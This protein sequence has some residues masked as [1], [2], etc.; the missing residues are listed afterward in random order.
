MA[1]RGTLFLDEIG[2]MPLTL[3]A[4]ILRALEEKR[5]ERVGGTASVQ[6]D[7]R[8]VA[9]TNRGLRAAIAARR[10]R[11]DLYFRLS[12]FP[13]TVPPLRDRPGDIILLARFFV[14]RFCR[15]MKKRPLALSP[16]AVEQLQ[17]YR[18]PGNVRELQNCIE[19]AVILAEAEAIQPRHLN[20]S[21]DAPHPGVPVSPWAHVDLS[22]SLAE[23]TRRVVFDVERVKLEEAL[24]EADNNKA[25]AADLSAD[26]LQDVRG[27]AARASPRRRAVARSPRR[28]PT[29]K[30]RRGYGCSPIVSAACVSSP[31]VTSVAVVVLPSPAGRTKWSRPPTT[32]LSRLA[33]STTVAAERSAIAGNGPIFAMSAPQRVAVGCGQ[34]A[35]CHTKLGGREHAV[36]D[37]LAVPE[38]LVLRDRFEGVADRMAEV[39]CAPR[40]G[41]AFVCLHDRAP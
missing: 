14:E 38:A 11:E 34:C 7:V 26:H 20:L 37:G 40:A 1:H 2:E 29:R 24:K 31:A 13:I 22:G 8:L 28:L 27:K 18:W 23:A 32:F 17:A 5:F 21:F 3:Q 16:A 30:R 15:D 6:V 33:A 19:R 36:R 10:F 25:R 9:A 4:K 41:L 12:V 39:Q 35:A